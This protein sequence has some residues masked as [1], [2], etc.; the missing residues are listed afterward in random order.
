MNRHFKA[1]CVVVIL[2]S[3][4]AP[5]YAGEGFGMMKKSANLTRIHP[6]QVFI[7][8]TRVS[9]KVTAASPNYG[10]AAQ[11]LESQLESE[12]LGK[13]QRLKLDAQ[14]PDATIDVKIL[15]DQ[16]SEKWEDRQMI[17]YVDHGRKDSKGR[18]VLD[19]EQ[20]TVRFKVVTYAFNAAFKVHDMQKD[21]SLAA[22]S[23][24]W[25]YNKDFQE[26]NGSPDASSLESSAVQACV[27]DLTNRLAPTKE[28]VGVLLPRGTFETAAAERS[29]RRSTVRE[30][31]TQALR[32]DGP[33]AAPPAASPMPAAER[34]LILSIHGPCIMRLRRRSTTHSEKQL[35]R[36][37]LRRL[38]KLSDAGRKGVGD[39]EI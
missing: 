23:I 26:G 5:L 10:V 12:L 24:N 6:P 3:A 25:S 7:A 2:L 22:D 4:S 38:M 39:G 29:R 9:I 34:W 19:Q 28:V 1:L 16:F 11:R 31:V 13:N 30:P 36:L 18:K 27:N 37:R 20:V 21:V 35:S 32:D 14:R 15:Q 8:G 17:R 33:A